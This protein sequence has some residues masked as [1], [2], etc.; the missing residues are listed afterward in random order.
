MSKNVVPIVLGGGARLFEGV[1]QL[2]L[3]LVRTI[4]APDVSHLKYRVTKGD[5]TSE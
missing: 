2:N 1:G 4:E 5:R 3:E